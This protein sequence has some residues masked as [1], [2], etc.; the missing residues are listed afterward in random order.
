MNS[1]GGYDDNPIVEGTG[2]TGVDLL[3]PRDP[4]YTGFADAALRFFRQREGHLF[5]ASGR[6][7]VNAFRNVGLKPGYGGDVQARMARPLGR[8]N[9][10]ELS[11]GVRSD[12][13]YSLG[14]FSSLR[15]DL[16]QSQLPDAN[17]TNGSYA[18]RS[19]GSDASIA[20]VGRWSARDTVNAGYRF[21]WR[22]FRDH[23][24][25]ATGHVGFLDYTHNFGRRS[26]SRISY[27]RSESEYRD[28][29]TDAEL[30]QIVD[31]VR[32]VTED[33]AELGYQ[34]ET[35]VSRTRSL[36]FA[37]GAGATHV[38]TI[39]QQSRDR[40]VYTLPSGYGSTR[41]DIGR[42]WSV[43]A[44]YRR[45]LSILE[46]ISVQQFVTDAAMIRVGG[47]AGSRS[48]IVFAGGYSSGGAAPGSDGS[49]ESYTAVTQ[50][51][52]R[53]T[54]SWY[55]LASHAYYSYR[56][57]GVEDLPSGFLNRLDRNAIRIGMT[58]E[59]PLYS[60]APRT[61]GRDRD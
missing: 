18:R 39:A 58:W 3:T 48:E 38:Q 53:V 55:L 30:N 36:L 1:L 27:R 59:L 17:P 22:E 12:S 25:D 28:R 6:G 46:G 15:A 13:F 29:R 52:F 60:S 50:F 23:V 61:S 47:S 40:L 16:G 9:G 41:L 7:Y 42:S 33:S 4:G 8:R 44:D 19:L 31:V 20:F 37:F 35:A 5:E 10:L 26:G 32:P 57:L 54:G 24:G 45:G 56:L 14:G 34:H 21:N 11:A 2:G 51:K 49:L 43:Q